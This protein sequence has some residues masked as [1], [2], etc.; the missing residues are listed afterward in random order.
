MKP[1]FSRQIFEKY[2][3]FMKIRPL[4]EPSYCMWTDGQPDIT[5]QIVI[6]HSFANVPNKWS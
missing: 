3:T 6:F 4:G 5:K 1:E 2:S